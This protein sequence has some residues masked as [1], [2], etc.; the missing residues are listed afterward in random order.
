MDLGVWALNLSLPSRIEAEGPTPDAH[1]APPWMVVHYDFPARGSA[2]AVRMHWYSG[3]KRPQVPGAPDLSK[4]GGG[5][6]FVGD[7]GMLL[8]DYGRYV[9]LPEE[10]FRGSTPPPRSIPDSIGHH[11]E[12]I[13]ACKGGP[14]APSN[15]EIAGPVTEAVLLG[16]VAIRSG[17]KLQWNA[18]KLTTGDAGADALLSKTYPAGWRI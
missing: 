18:R 11:E 1:C 8:A 14:K 12:W 2:P 10:Q 6:L 15:F 16:N 17:R 9:L 4:W 3:A 5:T 13:A 7:K